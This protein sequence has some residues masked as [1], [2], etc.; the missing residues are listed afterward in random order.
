MKGKRETWDPVRGGVPMETGSP[1]RVRE[2]LAWCLKGCGFF[3][4]VNQVRMGRVLMVSKLEESDSSL[5]GI[6]ERAGD[7]KRLEGLEPSWEVSYG[8]RTW[9]RVSC[10]VRMQLQRGGGP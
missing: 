5:C 8:Y 6:A 1:Y 4:G 3:A 10:Y 9:E 7:Y 2:G